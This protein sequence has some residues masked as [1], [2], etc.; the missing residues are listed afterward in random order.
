MSEDSN[1]GASPPPVG[2]VSEAEGTMAADLQGL[3]PRAATGPDITLDELQ[4]AVRNHSMH[5]E[6]L[7]YDITPVGMHYLLI[8]WDIPHVDA[9]GWR[10][11]LG[12]TVRKALTFTLDDLKALPRVSSQV[13]LECAGNG[14]ALTSPRPIS[15]PWLMEAVGNAEWIGTPLRNLL[16]AAGPLAGGVEVVFTGLDRGVQGGI[17][18]LYERSLTL[19]EASRAEALLAYEMNGRPLTPQHGFPLRLVIPGWYGM[20]HVKWLQSITVV[21]RPFRGYQQETAYRVATSNEDH[22]TP[23]GRILPRSLMVP[24]GVPDHM[25]RIRYVSPGDCM[26]EGRAWSGHGAIN[27]VQVS[28]DGGTSWENAELG[29]VPAEFAWRSWRYLWRAEAGEHQLSCRATDVAGNV[30]P[31]ATTWNA[32]GMCNNAVQRVKVVVGTDTVPLQPPAGP[33]S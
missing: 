18:Q 22:G 1:V 33:S 9:A 2:R 11:T 26:L 3:V 24:P 10:L 15:Q 19:A 6:A 28:V 17:E 31:L 16:E 30:Q 14:R 13:T 8:H 4:L 21:D 29:P 5:L 12:G 7:R 27:T 32:Q 25:S 23:V 20:A